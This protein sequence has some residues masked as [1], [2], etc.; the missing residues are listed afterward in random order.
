MPL[1]EINYQNTVIYKIQ[2]ID[3]DDLLYVGHTTDFTK[4]K[5]M[6]KSCCNNVTSKCFNLKIYKMIRENGGWE[7]F[8][9]AEVEKFPCND[10]NEADAEEDKVMRTLKANMN[11]IHSVL[12]V[13]HRKQWNSKVNCDCGKHY[14]RKHKSRHENSQ[15]HKHRL[16]AQQ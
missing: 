14:T 15:L 10:R 4:R 6:H 2:H 1:K 7:M 12:D 3:N 16:I 11:S 8:N 13:E 5:S 9:M